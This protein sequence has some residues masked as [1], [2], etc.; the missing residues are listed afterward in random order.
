VAFVLL[1]FALQPASQR[2]RSVG[3]TWLIVLGFF[4]TMVWTKCRLFSVPLKPLSILFHL[5]TLWV[6][7]G[8]IREARE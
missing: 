3:L 2:S 6:A 1:L 4:V 5:F 8:I 7:I